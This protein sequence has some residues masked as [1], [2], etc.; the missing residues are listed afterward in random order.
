MK[1]STVS[2][3]TYD[4]AKKFAK[5]VALEA[6]IFADFIAKTIQ[7]L[8]KS[9]RDLKPSDVD[10]WLVHYHEFLVIVACVYLEII[11]GV[12]VK[13]RFSSLSANETRRLYTE[14][15]PGNYADQWKNKFPSSKNPNNAAAPEN[16]IRYSRQCYSW[17]EGM[18][19][20]KAKTQATRCELQE[21]VC[22]KYYSS[23]L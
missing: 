11:Y 14:Q 23:S 20:L 3:L 10:D 17:F 15:P 4:D 5:E 12:H 6:E 16:E 9:L 21:M 22:L 7:S 13:E 18:F 2:S 1:V 19:W 8:D